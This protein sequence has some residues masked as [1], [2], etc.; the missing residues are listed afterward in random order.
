M[1]TPLG[2]RIEAGPD[3]LVVFVTGE[4]DMESAPQLRECLQSHVGRVVLDLSEVT[5]L[6]SSGIA[7]LVAARRNAL[8]AGVRLTVTNCGSSSVPLCTPK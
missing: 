2:I 3:E 4:I 1:C 8:A 6:D 7:T 5:F